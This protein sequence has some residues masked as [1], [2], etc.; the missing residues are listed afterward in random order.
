MTIESPIIMIGTHRSG[1]TWLGQVF[2]H[3]PSLAYWSEPRYVWEW[4]NNYKPDDLLIAEDASP[5]I[6]SHI[7]QRFSDFV[8]QEQK[9][10]LLEKTPSN[11][12]RL[13]FIN[14]IYPKAKIIHIIRD[15]RSVFCST[16]QI[17]NNR[18][19]RPEVLSNRLR[20]MLRE[21]PILGWPAY[22]PG[23]SKTIIGK[24]LHRP[25]NFWG[26]K[27]PGWR[28]WLNQDSKNI[29]LAQQWAAI[30]QRAINDG[31]K[32]DAEHYLKIYYED[33]IANPQQTIV[34]ILNFAELE[35]NQDVI[36]Y[37]KN[38]VDTTKKSPWR[39]LLDLET[40]VEIRPYLEPTLNQLG[41][42]W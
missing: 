35:I 31:K 38:T 30:V 2:S 8:E 16:N 24:L 42:Q 19:Y 10:R 40:L 41:Y 27:P 17:M 13:S 26:P 15:G 18:Y 22:I 23:I 21:T 3:H 25:I 29:I 32:I 6:I 7:R 36:D 20:E 4:G 28:E 5:Q 1:T 39:N 14:K 12:L 11:C 34:K 37:V 9:L 33:L